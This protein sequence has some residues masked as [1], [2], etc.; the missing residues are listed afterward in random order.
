MLEVDILQIHPFYFK[1]SLKF[2]V[3]IIPPIR[4]ILFNK[5]WCQFRHTLKHPTLHNAKKQIHLFILNACPS[6]KLTQFRPVFWSGCPNSIFDCLTIIMYDT[7]C[8]LSS[9]ALLIMTP[10]IF[11]LP[12]HYRL[13]LRFFRCGKASMILYWEE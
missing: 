9:L 4:E 11:F 8:T 13:V 6:K 12:F 1:K 5:T 3:E 2:H 7:L 10:S